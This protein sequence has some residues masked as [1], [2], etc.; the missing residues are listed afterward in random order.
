MA[1]NPHS[2]FY[3]DDSLTRPDSLTR[4]VHGADELCRKV[5]QLESFKPD[6]NSLKDASDKLSTLRTKVSLISANSAL[7]IKKTQEPVDSAVESDS[8][9]ADRSFGR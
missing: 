1:I 8:S 7:G 9:K 3:P 6:D 4:V 5:K 2:M